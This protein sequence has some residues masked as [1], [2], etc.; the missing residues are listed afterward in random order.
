MLFRAP[1]GI[2][3]FA[4]TQNPRENQKNQKNQILEAQWGIN[5]YPSPL[6]SQN[7]VFLVFLVFSR[8]FGFG[9]CWEFPG[10]LSFPGLCEATVEHRSREGEHRSRGGEHMSREG[11]HR[12]RG[13][14][15][16]IS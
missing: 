11:E 10:F 12:S 5:P 8:L 6:G 1:G 15:H 3:K 16:R 7:L 14:E 2:L 13:G 4:N 9:N